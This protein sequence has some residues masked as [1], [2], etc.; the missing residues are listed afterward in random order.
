MSIQKEEMN[1][2][3]KEEDNILN[4][5]II[6]DEKEN[7]KENLKEKAKVKTKVLT[8]DLGKIFEK[9][10][11]LLYDIEYDSKY[12]YSIEDAEKLKE[13]LLKFK[14]VFPFNIIHSAKNGSRYDFTGLDDLNIKLS[15]KTSKKDGKVCPQVIGQPTKK[16]F[17]EYFEIDNSC[18][19]EEIKK[20]IENNLIK[21][22]KKY[23]D[24]TF[25]CPIIYYNKHKNKLL[26]IKRNNMDNINYSIDWTKYNIEFSHIKKNKKWGESSSIS[27]NN[28]TIGEF[29]IHNHRDCIKIRWAFENLLG[30]FK[31][32]FNIKI[33]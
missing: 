21:L 4:P 25:D 29:Q 23:Y 33:L 6:I 15:A 9:S 19:L 11:C 14:E 8:E 13:R 18:D 2:E 12:K 30:L 27:I 17:C 31:D 10:I 24:F 16:R 22:L 5:N 20:Y 32:Y 3:I 28:I 1:Q 26:F 7:L